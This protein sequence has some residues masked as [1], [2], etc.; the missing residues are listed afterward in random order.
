MAGLREKF[1]HDF[2]KTMVHVASQRFLIKYIATIPINP[3]QQKGSDEVIQGFPDSK[4]DFM[5]W[6]EFRQIKNGHGMIISHTLFMP[7]S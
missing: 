6:G 2:D 4:I 7:C 5:K 3:V 1:H